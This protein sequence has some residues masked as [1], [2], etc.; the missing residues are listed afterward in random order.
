M[1]LKRR[2]KEE[3]DGGQGRQWLVWLLHNGT[4]A[5][6]S[7]KSLV[8]ILVTLIHNKLEVGLLDFR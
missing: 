8:L 4:F 3:V 5:K 6:M 1:A 7:T 2:K